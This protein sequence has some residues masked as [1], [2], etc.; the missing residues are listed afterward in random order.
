M[1][2]LRR[3]VAASMLGLTLA[4]LA[5]G[6]GSAAGSPASVARI[7][8][9]N[10]PGARVL[11]TTGSTLL[12][13]SYAGVLYVPRGTPAKPPLR[14][15][16]LAV[17]RG[18]HEL[19][20]PSLEDVLLLSPPGRWR[21]RES[22]IGS[23]EASSTRSVPASDEEPA[24]VE[25]TTTSV[26]FTWSWTAGMGKRG[27]GIDL[28]ADH[29]DRIEGGVATL[30][31]SGHYSRSAGEDG[32]AYSC[33]FPVA[34][35]QESDEASMYSPAKGATLGR[36]GRKEQISVQL[37]TIAYGAPAFADESCAPVGEGI[38]L[39]PSFTL[40]V[41]QAPWS[42]PL[43]GNPK[44]GVERDESSGGGEDVKKDYRTSARLEG[45]A[46]VELLGL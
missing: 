12:G 42:S 6:G 38:E 34:L 16:D 40:S 36:R 46:T 1:R 2:F 19:R 14:R 28:G 45:T 37:G 27:V 39:E 31:G 29:G 32:P 41:P 15:V 18:T 21:I 13:P 23:V 33:D 22:G 11:E 9:R 35:R 26:R 10:H 3:A 7:A 8:R 4:A 30:E 24:R 5:W 44:F 17:F 25:T 20:R 43:G